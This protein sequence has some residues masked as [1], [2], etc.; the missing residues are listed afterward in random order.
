MKRLNSQTQMP[1]KYGDVRE[2]GYVFTSYSSR[3][4]KN[5]FYVE[6]W[7]C[8]ESFINQKQSKKINYQKSKQK[9][10]DKNK[11]YYL[12]NKEEVC[13]KKQQY[14]K[15]NRARYNA[16]SVEREKAKSFR[17]PK[18]LTNEQKEEIIQFYEIAKQMK[19]TTGVAYHVDHI[20]PLCGKKV[21]G[22][23]VPWNLQVITAKENLSKYNKYSLD[24]T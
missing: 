3:I 6:Q 16:L 5:G 9:I 14:K 4:N 7:I 13:K 12:Q 19:E 20:I 11:Q 1:F 2:D 10:L 15:Q 8:Q 18:W 17:T 24:L 22:L 23:H 21:S